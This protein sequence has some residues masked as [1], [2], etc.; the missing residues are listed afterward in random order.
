MKMGSPVRQVRVAA[1][2]WRDYVAEVEID[3]DGDHSGG[4]GVDMVFNYSSTAG[5]TV[6][7]DLP[8]RGWLG[9]KGEQMRMTTMG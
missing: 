9:S 4:Q 5:G 7:W 1:L 6:M 2:G 3:H 8:F